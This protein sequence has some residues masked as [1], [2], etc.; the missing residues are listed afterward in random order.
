MS[1]DQKS[2]NSKLHFL[3]LLQNKNFNEAYKL[4]ANSGISEIAKSLLEYHCINLLFKN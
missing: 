1:K 4:Y 3:D 2:I